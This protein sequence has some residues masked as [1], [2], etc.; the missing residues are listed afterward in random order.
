MQTDNIRSI[1]YNPS[2]IF[3]E[4]GTN[5]YI[6]KKDKTNRMQF[7]TSIIYAGLFMEE[8]PIFHLYKHDLYLNGIQPDDHSY[9]LAH[10]CS[11][12]FYPL[13]VICS[14]G[15][16]IYAI[17]DDLLKSRWAELRPAIER[18]FAGESAERYIKATENNLYDKEKIQ[19]LIN[20]DIFFFLFFSL[21]YGYIQEKEE[22][23]IK[24]P[25]LAF[26]KAVSG[27]FSTKTHISEDN[28]LS[29]ILEGNITDDNI[30][31]YATLL[32]TF[33][34]EEAG[35]V[36]GDFT[37]TYQQDKDYLIDSIKADFHIKKEN[38]EALLDITLKSYYLSEYPLKPVNDTCTIALGKD[39]E[40]QQKTINKK[41]FWKKLQEHF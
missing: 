5:I 10:A 28:N 40:N 11:K 2:K 1:K 16:E 23:E 38:K 17:R 41:S 19:D 3:R 24:L 30:F 9:R 21:K 31:N 13:V 14:A 37:I 7:R 22:R 12:A 36:T 20:K 26:E 32:N 4:Y 33:S 39:I 35:K 15:N 29:V 8:L 27:K 25:L 18:E 34:N 6:T